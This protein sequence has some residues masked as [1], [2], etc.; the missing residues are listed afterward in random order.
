MGFPEVCHHSS[1]QMCAI[2]GYRSHERP[3]AKRTDFSFFKHFP[4]VCANY[5][6]TPPQSPL[7]LSAGAWSMSARSS[8]CSAGIHLLHTAGSVPRLNGLS[9]TLLL[10]CSDA[11]AR[12]P[13]RDNG[14]FDRK[15]KM[16]SVFSLL[17]SGFLK[18][19]LLDQAGVQ[20]PTLDV[21]CR[22]TLCTL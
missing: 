17:A 2:D 8:R 19:K 20:S 5:C 11:T 21:V 18:K 4:S 6:M 7:G 14:Y 10:S 15:R 13:S 9:V 1:R 3:T 22:G 12:P 16:G